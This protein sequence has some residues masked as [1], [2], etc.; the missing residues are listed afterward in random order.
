MFCF[1]PA[2]N[3]AI[4]HASVYGG[5]FLIL[6]SRF[7]WDFRRLNFMPGSSTPQCDKRAKFWLNKE[8]KNSGIE[9]ANN[10]SSPVFWNTPSVN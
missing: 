1:G 7:P 3:S 4:V 10:T 9:S 5:V 2:N 6:L 8:A